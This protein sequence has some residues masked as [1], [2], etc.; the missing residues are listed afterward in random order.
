MFYAC[1][2]IFDG[3][4]EYFLG[5]DLNKVLQDILAITKIYDIK[6]HENIINKGF[7]HT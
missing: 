6:Y 4:G 3:I 7:N 2:Q 1:V 5:S